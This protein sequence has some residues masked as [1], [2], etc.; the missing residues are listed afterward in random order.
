MATGGRYIMLLA[1]YITWSFCLLVSEEWCYGIH[2]YIQINNSHIWSCEQLNQL[3]NNTTPGREK[4]IAETQPPFH[5]ADTHSRHFDLDF[6]ACYTHVSIWVSPSYSMMLS[7]GGFLSFDNS[8]LHDCTP[9]SW[10]WGSVLIT[11][12]MCGKQ[13]N[14]LT[15]SVDMHTHNWMPCF[16][17][18]LNPN[19]RCGLGM[20]LLMWPGN[21]AHSPIILSE[22][23]HLNAWML[24]FHTPSR[25]TEATHTRSNCKYHKW[26]RWGY[27]L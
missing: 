19:S 5:W 22:I 24:E 27:I 10:R 8:F 2:L 4:K 6:Q 23:I 13:R 12:C 14:Q 7:S 3:R 15:Y 20:R 1:D 26:W 9:A 25:R 18:L 21:E 17:H 16:I 11:F